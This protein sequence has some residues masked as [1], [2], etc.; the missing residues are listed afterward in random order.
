MRGTLAKA[1]RRKVYGESGTG[2][3]RKWSSTEKPSG[4]RYRI[5]DRLNRVIGESLRIW[6]RGTVTAD[7]QRQLYQDI[8]RMRRGLSWR[9][10]G[11]LA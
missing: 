7:P 6:W 2:R 11:G 8:K 1:I 3:L 9:K 5:V 4:H 10:V